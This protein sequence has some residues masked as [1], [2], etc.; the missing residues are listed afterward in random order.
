MKT[1]EQLEGIAQ[2]LVLRAEMMKQM[3]RMAKD[4]EY[5]DILLNIKIDEAIEKEMEMH[6]YLNR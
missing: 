2:E 1:K 5:N 6:D 4:D 3:P